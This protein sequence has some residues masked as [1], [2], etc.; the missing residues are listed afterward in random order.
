MRSCFDHFPNLRSTVR[1]DPYHLAL[2]KVS[3]NGCAGGVPSTRDRSVVRL[4]WAEPAPPTAGSRARSHHHRDVQS[5]HRSNDGAVR[6][7]KQQAPAGPA[8][9][10]PFL[11]ERPDGAA[12]FHL[13]VRR[14]SDHRITT[15]LKGF[16]SI[17]HF[18][19]SEVILYLVF[20]KSRA[21]ATWIMEKLRF[22]Y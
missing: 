8:A 18:K 3:G 21:Q 4:C 11:G 9:R 12:I 17:L 6:L 15:A 7:I 2:T 19:R 5:P 10:R 1:H 16:R 22:T 14:E 20:V 13:I